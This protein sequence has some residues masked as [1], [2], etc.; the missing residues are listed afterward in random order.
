MIQATASSFRSSVADESHDAHPSEATL[1]AASDGLGGA[2]GESD[3]FLDELSETKGSSLTEVSSSRRTMHVPALFQVLNG[4][5]TA[6][7]SHDRDSGPPSVTDLA[8]L[9]LTA[10][11]YP[12]QD[13]RCQVI[14]QKLI[15]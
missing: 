4:F 5:Y 2:I 15:L 12:L 6:A 14:G 1:V 10:S 9:A 11:G 3:H 8:Y 7:R 13:V